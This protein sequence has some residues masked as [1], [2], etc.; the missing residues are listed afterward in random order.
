MKPKGNFLDIPKGQHQHKRLPPR[1]FG[2]ANVM[3]QGLAKQRCGRI[4]GLEPGLGQI[5]RQWDCGHVCARCTMYT[6]IDLPLGFSPSAPEWVQVGVGSRF[7]HR[8][9]VGLRY[10]HQSS[11][12][13][14]SA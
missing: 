2:N 11:R 7:Q 5:M 1:L 13:I 10:T 12:D 14:V 6:P 8:P 9:V 3:R 4:S